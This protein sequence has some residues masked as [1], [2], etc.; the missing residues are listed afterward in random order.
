VNAYGVRYGAETV[1]VSRGSF[2]R[3]LSCAIDLLKSWTLRIE[4]VSPGPLLVAL[5][6]RPLSGPN[7][8][9]PFGGL[10]IMLPGRL[11]AWRLPVAPDAKAVLDERN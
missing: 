9:M 6:M 11:F 3:L 4:R 1:E 5:T 10:R 2:A 8:P 7:R